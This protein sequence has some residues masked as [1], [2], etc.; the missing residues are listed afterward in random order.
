[1][2]KL[3]VVLVALILIVPATTG[4]QQKPNELVR[5]LTEE[6]DTL[7]AQKTV[8]AVTGALMR[9][10]GDTLVAK[11]L[12]GSFTPALAR[13]WQVS[14]DGLTWT[15]NLRSGVRFHDGTPFNAQAVKFTIDRALAPETKS[16]IAAAL[17]GPVQ[18]VTI[19]DA[20]TVVIKLKQPFAIFL[21][22]LTDPRALMISPQAVQK[23]GDGFGRQPV[24]T[25]PYKFEEWR[26]AD[27]IIL[28]R[29]PDY[30]WGPHF[31]HE[32]PPNIE[33]IVYRIIPEAAAQVAAFER[34]EADI[35]GVPSTDLKRLQQTSKYTFFKAL[36][37]GVGLYIEFNTQ[38]E[39]FTDVRVRRALN[40]AIEKRSVLQIALEGLGVVAD[41]V[42]PPSIWGYWP[43]M[44]EYSYKYDP[45][46]AK[47]AL[48]E[49][50]WT[51]GSGGT[52]QKG[53]QPFRFSLYIAPI[54]SWRRSAQIV[55]SQ[56]RAF[57]IQMDIETFEFA[58]LLAK[59]R[60]GEHQANFLGYTY[61][62]PDIVYVWFH[63]SNINTGLANSHYKD[64]KLDKLIE[65]S[66]TITD[67]QKRLE[68]Y[69]DIQKYIN[70]I[71]L[72]VPL[73]TNLSYTATQPRLQ[74]VKVHV[75]DYLVLNDATLK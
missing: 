4:A 25:G 37:K 56:L 11:D 17:F 49:A 6:P 15:F 16:P 20:Q 28:T 36:R 35:L 10:I 73:W 3:A 63:S 52:L 60:A 51:P 75:D 27:R 34:G 61:T 59:L 7:D 70:D 21:D 46:A 71:A 65:D 54:D 43:G 18:S 1:M 12:D 45:G 47:R 69:R 31:V 19:P 44:E 33:R 9:L 5:M 48:A 2:R 32:G 67:T 23:L 38:R 68:L 53:G 40:Q 42:L 24:A 14:R 64:P 74:G 22:N 29:N 57:G 58:T 62:S 26:S 50:G 66:R 72:W 41:G 39:P 13:A 8:T 30:K 55:Q